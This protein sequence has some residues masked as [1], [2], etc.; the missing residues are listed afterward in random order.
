MIKRES[1]HED[2]NMKI[3]I[4][5]VHA[6]KKCVKINEV[7]TENWKEKKVKGGSQEESDTP[8]LAWLTSPDAMFLLSISS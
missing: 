7:K 2:I 8:A 6:P 1:L 3:W 5:N 4:L